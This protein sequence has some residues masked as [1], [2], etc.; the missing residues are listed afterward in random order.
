MHVG[1]LIGY[2]EVQQ[3]TVRDYCN[4]QQGGVLESNRGQVCGCT[5]RYLGR[6]VF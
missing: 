3:T 4:G 2:L 1:W 6:E 5:V